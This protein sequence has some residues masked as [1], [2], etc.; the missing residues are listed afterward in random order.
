M[1]LFCV[2][3]FQSELC[4]YESVLETPQ[5]Q[6]STQQSDVPRPHNRNFTQSIGRHADMLCTDVGNNGKS[7]RVE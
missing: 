1:S 7:P 6:S 2:L 4:C 3:Y 5:R